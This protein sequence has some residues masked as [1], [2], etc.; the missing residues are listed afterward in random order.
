MQ[1]KNNSM[2]TAKGYRNHT[3]SSRLSCA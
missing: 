3:C 2:R 1:S